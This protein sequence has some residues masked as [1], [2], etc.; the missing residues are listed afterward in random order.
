MYWP[1]IKMRHRNNDQ[2]HQIQVEKEI[3]QRGLDC[4]GIILYTFREANDS[5]FGGQEF[6][7]N[8][9]FAISLFGENHDE[10]I[11][12]FL[13]TSMMVHLTL[14]SLISTDK[15]TSLIFSIN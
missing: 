1:K 4:L 13:A 5:I 3:V 15:T 9:L 2:G 7:I 8:V 6:I 14:D 10:M 12:Q 11:A